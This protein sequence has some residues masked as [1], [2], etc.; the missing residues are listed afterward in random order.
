MSS[1]FLTS[2]LLAKRWCLKP[3]TLRQWRWNGKGPVYMKIGRTVLYRL[4]DI[5]HF[6]LQKVRQNTTQTSCLMN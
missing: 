3:S 4:Q 1:Q 2:T 6:E 5:E